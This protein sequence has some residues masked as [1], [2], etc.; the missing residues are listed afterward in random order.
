MFFAPPILEPDPYNSGVESSHLYQLFLGKLTFSQ[1]QPSQAQ[2]A[3][4]SVAKYNVM[5][6]STTLALLNRIELML[7][8]IIA[9]YWAP[10]R[11][12]GELCL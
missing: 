2:L 7:Q 9:L 6:P 5:S 11:E 12:Q 4:L 1:N 3:G 8:V 10:L